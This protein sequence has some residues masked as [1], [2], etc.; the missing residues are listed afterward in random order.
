VK[1]IVGALALSC[2]ILS[3]PLPAQTIMNGLEFQALPRIS[4]PASDA[5]TYALGGGASLAATF[6]LPLPGLR[7]GPQFGF[8]AQPLQIGAGTV[9][10]ISLGAGAK[11][12]FGVSPRFALA[13]YADGGYFLSFLSGSSGSVGRSVYL[14]GGLGVDFMM[15]EALTFGLDA[16][17]RSNIGLYQS[18]GLGLYASLRP[19]LVGKQPKGAAPGAIPGVVPFVGSTKLGAG[20]QLSGAKFDPIFPVLFKYYD[21]HPIGKVVVR[22]GDKVG[23]RDIKVSFFVN[24]YMDNPKVCA[25]IPA[26]APGAEAAVDLYALFNDKMLDISEGTKVSA[27][28]S[29]EYGPSGKSLGRELSDTIRIYDRNASMWDDD[30]K[31]A[32]FVTSKDPTVLRFSK[33]VMAMVKDKGN[34]AVDPKLLAAMAFHQATLLYGLTY[35]TDPTNSYAETLNS[36]TAVDFLQFPRQT[37]D[38]KAGN[39]SALSILYSALLESV[40]IETAFITVPGHILMAVS[41]DIPPSRARSGFFAPADLII[42]DDHVWLPIETTERSAGFVQAWQDGAKEW[43]DYLAKGQAVLYPVHEAWALYE[44]VGFAP[45]TGAIALP[46]SG[47]VADSFSAELARYVSAEIYP[48]VSKLQAEIKSSKNSPKAINQLGVLYGRYG[49]VDKAEAQFTAA[50]K[51]GDY[52]PALINLGNL[53]YLRRQYALSLGYFDKAQKLAPASAAALLAVARANDAL[54]NYGAAKLA[55]DKLKSVDPALA[56]KFDYLGT[57]AGDGLRAADIAGV[58]DVVVWGEE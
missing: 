14:E 9:S 36:K 52:A 45:D 46:D 56:K 5:D 49:L 55:Y 57:K 43:R 44:P 6:A 18:Y 32:A 58:K 15:S 34:S 22:N 20:L 42:T 25:T 7:L 33:N 38:Y 24:Q 4:L 30:R 13:P 19:E 48:A 17:Y 21:D 40:G 12:S 16:S 23:A 2:A 51:T 41:L 8:I 26:L 1:K 28:V 10:L 37:L 50:L 35:V 47:K 27:K 53:A 54:E 31:A 3:M 29:V 39:C 11:Y